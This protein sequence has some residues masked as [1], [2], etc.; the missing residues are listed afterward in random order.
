[1]KTR[2]QMINALVKDQISSII[3]LAQNGDYLEL[4]AWLSPV[5]QKDYDLCS[6]SE[7]I[8]CY[9]YSGLDTVEE[10]NEIQS[11]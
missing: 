11:D 4:E 2:E 10:V 6:D 5:F 9:I 3:Q 8:G 7:I 1:M